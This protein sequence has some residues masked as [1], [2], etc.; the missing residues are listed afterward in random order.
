MLSVTHKPFIVS[1]IRL[2]V[3]NK[4]TMLSVIMMNV[5]MLIVIAPTQNK[6]RP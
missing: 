6:A 5:V 4:P 1:Y 2:S 3:A